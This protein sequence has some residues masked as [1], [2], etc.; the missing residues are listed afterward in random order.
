M[1]T[2]KRPLKFTSRSEAGFKGFN[3]DAY[4]TPPVGADIERLGTCVAVADGITLCPKG[5]ELA[6]DAVEIVNI[7]YSLAQEEGPGPQT[8]DRA[9]DVLWT[10]FFTYVEKHNDDEYLCS[11]STLTIVL[12]LDNQIH[13]RHM[14]DSS[15]DIFLPD[16]SCTRITEEHNTPDGCLINYFGGELQ[17]PAQSEVHPFPYG[18]KVILAS[19]GIGYF[20]EPPLTNTLGE[21]LKWRAK[22]LINEMFA[23]S[24]QAGSLD[25]RTLVLGF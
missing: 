19:D 2:T 11:G 5:G 4:A 20:I 21:R 22:D 24:E 13:L 7:Y 8:L 23:L 14:G 1:G 12:I 10:K 17:T 3:Q 16:G 18:S 15:C 25:D 6:K 9:L